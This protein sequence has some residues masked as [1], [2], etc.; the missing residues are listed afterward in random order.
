MLLAKKTLLSLALVGIS[1]PLFGSTR[2]ILVT[3]F[4]DGD[5]IDTPTGPWQYTLWKDPVGDAC[6]LLTDTRHASGGNPNAWRENAVFFCVGKVNRHG[7]ILAMN[8]SATYTPGAGGTSFHHL[9]GSVD[10][11]FCNPLQNMAS[12]Y[13]VAEQGGTYYVSD[14]LTTAGSFTPCAMPWTS[15]FR[16]NL[17][18]SNFYEINL[19]T[20][21]FNVSSHPNFANG[22]TVT[23]GYLVWGESSPAP[24]CN[25]TYDVDNWSVS[26]YRN[27]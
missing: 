14:P 18:A 11:K 4:S 23:F 7:A 26:V 20:L 21:Q 5:F 13:I 22:S 16:N 10:A 2:Q 27:P 9:N 15:W 3:T 24:H 25:G 12:I 17:G 8:T 1:I 6:V 19:T